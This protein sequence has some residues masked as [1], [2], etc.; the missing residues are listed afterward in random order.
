MAQTQKIVELCG[1]SRKLIPKIL[2]L[3]RYIYL[4]A[5]STKGETAADSAA[6]RACIEAGSRPLFLC[7]GQKWPFILPAWRKARANQKP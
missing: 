1:K 6:A 5:L 7:A 3:C 4:F 2:R